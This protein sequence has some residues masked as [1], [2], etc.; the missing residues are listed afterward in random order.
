M[1]ERD[2]GT[3]AAKKAGAYLLSLYGKRASVEYK[4]DMSPVTAADLQSSGVIRAIIAETF[5]HHTFLSEE[6]PD[7]LE[8]SI[9][10]EPTWVVDP[11]DGTSNFI[12]SIP[13]FA[14]AIGL[15]VEK[16]TQL[17][18]IFDPLH[19]DLFV[20]EAGGGATLNGKPIHVSSKNHAQGAMLFAGRGYRERDRERHGQ[21]I[22]ALE[23]QTTYFRRLGCATM[24]LASVAAG[25]AD[26]VILTG[27]KPWDVV[28]GAL[29]VK[30]AGGRVTDY[31]GNPWDLKSEDLV[32]TNGLIHDELIQI[33]REQN[34]DDCGGSSTP[35]AENG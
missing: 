26:S 25:R 2:V 3:L 19:N 28:A 33:T 32:A 9:G 12:A 6:L 11:L 8:R 4:S 17:G 24:M 10:S 20:A 21:I 13:L 18:I 15:V 22:Y 30:Q 31:C 29:L 27:N 5:P 23:R 1:T 34:Q 16:Q 35:P 14:V 7:A